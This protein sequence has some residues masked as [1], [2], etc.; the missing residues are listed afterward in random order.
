MKLKKLE[1]IEAPIS[2]MDQE[3]MDQILAGW[4][5]FSFAIGEQCKSFDSE[6]KC[7]LGGYTNRNYCLKYAGTGYCEKYVV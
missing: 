5:C 4:I 6:A 3:A 2:E 1:L 7:D